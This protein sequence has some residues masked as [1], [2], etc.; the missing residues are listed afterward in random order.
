MAQFQSWLKGLIGLSHPVPFEPRGVHP[1]G[2]IFRTTAPTPSSLK[3]FRP[4]HCGRVRIRGGHGRLFC[5]GDPCCGEEVSVPL[6][7]SPH[8]CA[9][10]RTHKQ[11]RLYTDRYTLYVTETAGFSER[12]KGQII[13][14]RLWVEPEK[15]RFNIL[16][17]L[18]KIIF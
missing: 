14:I 3:A 2:A 11:T 1:E 18:F 5:S 9:H 12:L 6:A 13:D 8:T 7:P 4:V 16:L 17:L 15:L 10:T